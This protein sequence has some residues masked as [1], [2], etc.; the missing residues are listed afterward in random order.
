MAVSV[1]KHIKGNEHPEATAEEIAVGDFQRL[2]Q[3]YV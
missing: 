2:N 1:L 3:A